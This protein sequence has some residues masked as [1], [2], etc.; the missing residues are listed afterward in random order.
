MYEDLFKEGW[1]R[2][3][4]YQ[5]QI[6]RK[7]NKIFDWPGGTENINYRLNL[8]M[9]QQIFLAKKVNIKHSTHM[10]YNLMKFDVESEEDRS[11]E[12]DDKCTVSRL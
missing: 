10:D 5:T 11:G 9:F 8:D 1:K 4:K 3:Y 2:Q 12:Y 7:Q 6:N